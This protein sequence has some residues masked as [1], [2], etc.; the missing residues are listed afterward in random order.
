MDH[1]A[2]TIMP[3]LGSRHRRTLQVTAE[4][5][6]A[7]PGTAGLFGEIHFPDATILGMQ[8]AAPPILIK[9][10]AKARQ[11]TGVDARIVVTQ[12]VNNGV[13]PD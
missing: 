12:Q 11:A 1:G 8:V 10:M 5:F 7:A 4:V 13:A 2:A 3:E 6:H 9:D